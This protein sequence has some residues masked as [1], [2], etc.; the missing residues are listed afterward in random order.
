MILSLMTTDHWIFWNIGLL[1]VGMI[2]SRQQCMGLF[3]APSNWE[4]N[5][6]H[7][8]LHFGWEG[9]FRSRHLKEHEKQQASQRSN[10]PLTKITEGSCRMWVVAPKARLNWPDLLGILC[11]I[12]IGMGRWLGLVWSWLVHKC[13]FKIEELDLSQ[14]EPYIT[15]RVQLHYT[16]AF[17]TK[18]RL[19]RELCYPFNKPWACFT[20]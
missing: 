16:L 1:Y 10:K 5:E 4:G 6:W 11:L 19:C 17:F 20:L 12:R 14:A 15:P 13:S 9:H 7:W 18:P 8:G 2:F 3:L